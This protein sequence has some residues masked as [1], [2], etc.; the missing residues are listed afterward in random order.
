MSNTNSQRGNEL[1]TQEI[2]EILDTTQSQELTE[3]ESKL[4]K[5]IEGYVLA[6][7]FKSM[8]KLTKPVGVRNVKGFLKNIFGEQAMYA[9]YC[10]YGKP[11]L[12]RVKER[13]K[14]QKR[15]VKQ[16]EKILAIQKEYPQYN[17]IKAYQYGY[18]KGKFHLSREDIETFIAMLEILKHTENNEIQKQEKSQ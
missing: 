5:I 6:F 8:K 1:N 7:E 11:A 2:Q 18:M 3:Q 15:A 4:T 14:K 13:V 12:L 10:K 16:S 17:I 9:I